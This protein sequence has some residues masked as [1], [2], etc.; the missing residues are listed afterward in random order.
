MQAVAPAR[1]TRALELSGYIAMRRGEHAKASLM[2]KQALQ[3]VTTFHQRERQITTRIYT[4]MQAMQTGQYD[5]ALTVLLQEP[6][7]DA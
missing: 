6:N 4:A 1:T 2:L 3:Q 7:L 5:S